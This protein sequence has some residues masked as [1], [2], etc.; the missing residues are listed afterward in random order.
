[1]LCWLN[2]KTR[3]AKGFSFK[4]LM[5]AEK[6]DASSETAALP[7]AYGILGNAKKR[8]S[9]TWRVFAYTYCYNYDGHRRQDEKDKKRKSDSVPF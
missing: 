3:P 1:M 4:F 6:S 5:Q 9:T 8:Y 2:I 7:T